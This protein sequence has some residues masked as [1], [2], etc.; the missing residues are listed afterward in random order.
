MVDFMHVVRQE[1]IPI[2]ESVQR[3]L[4]SMGYSQGRFMVDA[5]RSAFSEHAVHDFQLKIAR[6]LG[7]V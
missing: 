5:A 3:G 6:A 7:A 4:H 1:D 2:C